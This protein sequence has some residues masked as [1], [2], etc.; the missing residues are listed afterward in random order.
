VGYPTQKP[1]LLVERIISLVTSPGNMVLDPFC[2]SGTTLVAAELLGRNS[3][4]IDVACKAV[5]LSQER[6]EQPFKTTSEL[7]RRGRETYVQ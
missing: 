6:L 3:L 5:Q 2:G 7:M 4:G 1:I